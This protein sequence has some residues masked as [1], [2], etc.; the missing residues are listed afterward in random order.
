MVR[1][2]LFMLLA[3]SSKWCVG[4]YVGDKCPEDQAMFVAE[5]CCFADLVNGLSSPCLCGLTMKLWELESVTQVNN[6]DLH[7][8]ISVH[9]LIYVSISEGRAANCFHLLSLSSAKDLVKFMDSQW[10]FPS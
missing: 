1:N 2:K 6:C 4:V 5:K 9:V 10:T 8:H 7:V 3:C